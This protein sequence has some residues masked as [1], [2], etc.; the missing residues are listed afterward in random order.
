MKTLAVPLDLNRILSDFSDDIQKKNVRFLYSLSLLPNRKV[1]FH[2]ADADGIVSAAILKTLKEFQTAIYIP[3]GFQELHHLELA[4]FF[5]TLNWCAIVDL[6][7]FNRSMM[8]LYCDHHQ[9]NK[10]LYKNAEIVIFD[11]SAPSA[12]Y[13]LAKHYQSR[14]PD[15]LKLLA[16]L[17][18]ITDTAGFTIA[19]PENI[20]SHILEVTRQEQAWLLDDICRLPETSEE[21]LTLVQDFSSIQLQVFENEFY[22]KRILGLR[23]Q[24]KRSIRLAEEFETKDVVIIIQGKTKFLKSAVVRRLFEKGVFITCVLF[25]G[26]I[27]TGISLRVNPQIPNSE[28]AHYQVETLAQE[29]AGGGHPRAAG[30][31]GPSLSATLTKIIEWT[32]E[33]NFNYRVYDLRKNQKVLGM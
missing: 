19:S 20:P 8:N 33:R 1:A 31:R 13:L 14:L 3:L 9:S 4:H 23:S 11:E 6:P 17:T 2:S 30:G 29:F 7:P 28:L 25:P 15:S 16:D 21:I 32:Q 27:F 12:A 24:R 18:T 26:K 22:R 10:T 5:Q